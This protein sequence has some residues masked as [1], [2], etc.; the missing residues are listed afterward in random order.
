MESPFKIKIEP[1]QKKHMSK[2][3]DMLQSISSYEPVK[4]Q[5]DKIWESFITQNNVH[6]FVALLGNKQQ[7]DPVFMRHNGE[8]VRT[9]DVV[10]Y[11]SIVI[12]KKIR[13]S[14]MGHIEDVVSDEN[15][16]AIGAGR[17]IIDHLIGIAKQEKCYKI[18]LNCTEGNIGFY[19]KCGFK[20]NSVAMTIFKN[21]I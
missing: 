20:L 15:F 17:A 4:N 21:V 18:N 16:R 9:G 12:E 19:E 10:G 7:H 14:T 13:G 3:I 5:L 1:I 2:V 6:P 8:F 11:G